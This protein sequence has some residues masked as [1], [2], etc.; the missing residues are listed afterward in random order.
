MYEQE[1]N[2]IIKYKY[3]IIEIQDM[4]IAKTKVIPAII[5]ATGTISKSENT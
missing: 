1:E 2:C 4:W 3:L 5:G